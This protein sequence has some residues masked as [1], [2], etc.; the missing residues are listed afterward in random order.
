ML[1]VPRDLRGIYV[2][3]RKSTRSSGKP[4]LPADPPQDLRLPLTIGL[5]GAQKLVASECPLIPDT[6]RES[7]VPRR[8]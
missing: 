8:S 4:L 7:R 1:R 2:L 5:G 6:P 3:Y